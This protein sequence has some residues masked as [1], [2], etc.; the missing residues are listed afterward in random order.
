[1]ACQTSLRTPARVS[2]RDAIEP[3]GLGQLL[4]WLHDDLPGLATHGQARLAV[5][6]GRRVCAV[7]A[8]TGS[9][10]EELITRATGKSASPSPELHDG[11]AVCV[12]AALYA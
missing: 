5:A 11:I 4:R 6:D 12:P 3:A 7:P 9:G 1:M 10:P 2:M 8:S